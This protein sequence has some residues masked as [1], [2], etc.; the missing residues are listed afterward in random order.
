VVACCSCDDG[1]CCRKGNG[2]IDFEEFLTLFKDEST[3]LV[4]T[5]GGA[6]TLIAAGIQ[7]A[8]G[9]ATPPSVSRPA[10]AASAS[11][12]SEGTEE[13]PARRLADLVHRP[14]SAGGFLEGGPT[15][16]SDRAVGLTAPSIQEEAAERSEESEEDETQ[17]VTG[18]AGT[19]HE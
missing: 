17:A 9:G 16:K 5:V 14:S 2:Q 18:L 19:E 13:P 10:A 7:A 4:K 1:C 3:S 11:A 12:S 15:T 8:T 6:T